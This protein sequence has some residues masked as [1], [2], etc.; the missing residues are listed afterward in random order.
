MKYV[1]NDISMDY[2]YIHAHTHTH[3]HTH[4]YVCIYIIHRYKHIS[5]IDI[6]ILNVYSMN[7]IK[8]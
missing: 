8:C 4:I 2:W 1:Y 6:N 5:Y 3:T 7:N